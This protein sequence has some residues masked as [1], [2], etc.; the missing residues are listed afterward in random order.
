CRF[1]ETHKQ[2]P[3]CRGHQ[4]ARNCTK[5]GYPKTRFSCS[6]SE[7]YRPAR[8]STSRCA[9]DAEIHVCPP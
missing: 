3:T 5:C 7:C 1:G 6:F 2:S 4:H 9:G 8:T